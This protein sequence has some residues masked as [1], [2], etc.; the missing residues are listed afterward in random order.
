MEQEQ[1]NSPA[2]SETD[3]HIVGGRGESDFDIDHVLGV[4]SVSEDPD[5][6]LNQDPHLY[7]GVNSGIVGER[8]VGQDVGAHGSCNLSRSCRAAISAAFCGSVVFPAFSNDFTIAV[9][10]LSASWSIDLMVVSEVLVPSRAFDSPR[11][12]S[13]LLDDYLMLS[14]SIAN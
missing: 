5:K 9:R 4:G 6:A 7:L 8:K 11:D 2:V 13:S 14:V 12:S 10:L 3:D 1:L